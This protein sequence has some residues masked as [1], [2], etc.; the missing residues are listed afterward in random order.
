[1]LK[2]KNTNKEY[3]IGLLDEM[4][5]DESMK[6]ELRVNEER[7][8]GKIIG[9]SVSLENVNDERCHGGRISF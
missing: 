1:M 9:L 3:I 8:N 7:I 4:A 2:I 6:Y 5:E